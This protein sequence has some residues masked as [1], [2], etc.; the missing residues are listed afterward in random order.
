MA[1]S[2]SLA[3]LL[4]PVLAIV[5]FATPAALRASETDDPVRDCTAT[6]QARLAPLEAAVARKPRNGR[7]DRAAFAAEWRVENEPFVIRIER[8][9]C[10]G[11]T[12]LTVAPTENADRLEQRDILVELVGRI[13][14]DP[15]RTQLRELFEAAA[16]VYAAS[17]DTGAVITLWSRRRSP[18]FPE[19][20]WMELG[21]DEARLLWTEKADPSIR[22]GMLE[23]M[24]ADL[25]ARD[26]R[27]RTWR[28]SED[29]LD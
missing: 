21:P 11:E 17:N 12:T 10:D 2:C 27:P 13:F 22:K 1:R 18:L 15:H 26:G 23:L 5:P 19:G 24:A 14:S 29:A 8:G 6:P 7:L 20:A 28:R 25:E 4:L 3:L 9:A 16:D